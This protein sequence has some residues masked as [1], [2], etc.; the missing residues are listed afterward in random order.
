MTTRKISATADTLA[1]DEQPHEPGAK[2]VAWRHRERGYELWNFMANRGLA[3]E[4]HAA[5]LAAE[6]WEVEPL[7][8]APPR[9]TRGKCPTC[10]HCPE[11]GGSGQVFGTNANDETLFPCGTCS[12]PTTRVSQP[13]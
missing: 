11:C 1:A 3:D 7:Y 9:E 13:R 12:P 10:G 2:P 4:E 5:D 8:A 6:G